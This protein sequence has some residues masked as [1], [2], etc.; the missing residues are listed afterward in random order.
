MTKKLAD[1]FIVRVIESTLRKNNTHASSRSQEFETPFNEQDVSSNSTLPFALSF[2]GQF[3][4]M[5]NLCIFY[6]P[7]EGRVRHE[8]IE[9]EISIILFVKIVSRDVTRK[10]RQTVA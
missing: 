9:V 1:E 10:S 3:E 4:L 5:K 6:V 8:H 2:L 7:S